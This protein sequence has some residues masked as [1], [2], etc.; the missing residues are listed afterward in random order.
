MKDALNVSLSKTFQ[1]LIKRILEAIQTER[2]YLL[3]VQGERKTRL[4]IFETTDIENDFIAI[5]HLL[6]LT[7]SSESKSNEVIQEKIDAIA[8]DVRT[9][10][11]IPTT[12]SPV[13][14]SSSTGA[15]PTLQSPK[16]ETGCVR[17]HSAV[18]SPKRCPTRSWSPMR[19]VSSFR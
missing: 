12:T 13:P 16:Q 9:W 17:G 10:L 14:S 18:R 2:I 5:Y 15:S 8:K 11:T 6:I 7:A 4:S 1:E 19:Q 3:G